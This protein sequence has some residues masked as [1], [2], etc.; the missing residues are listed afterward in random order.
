MTVAGSRPFPEIAEALRA[1]ASE[2]NELEYMNF[3]VR[4]TGSSFKILRVDT[5]ADLCYYLEHFNDKTAEFIRRK[6]AAKPR[7]VGFK[8]A[9]TII[10]RYLW[11]FR[12]KRH[13]S[14]LYVPRLER[15]CVMTI[16]TNSPRRRRKKWAHE[17]DFYPIT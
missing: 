10:D 14:G 11:S 3:A 1:I 17:R 8:R 15:L 12:A 9:M 7:F 4:L 16:T 6:R 13:V 5:G 2:F